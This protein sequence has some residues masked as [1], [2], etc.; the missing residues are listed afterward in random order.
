MAPDTRLALCPGTFDPVTYGHLDVISRASLRPS[1]TNN[2]ATKSS[3]ARLVSA[4]IR[5]TEGASG[6]VATPPLL[7]STAVAVAGCNV[8]ED[9]DPGSVSILL[10]NGDGT[11]Q[12]HVDFTV[13]L[14]PLAPAIGD[15]NG[16]GGVDLVVSNSFSNTVSVMLNL[17]VMAAF[18]SSINFGN[19]IV[20]K[21]SEPE[22]VALSNPSGTP[23]NLHSIAITGVNAADFAQNNNCPAELS[24][25][26]Q[27]TINVTFKPR[28]KG[29]RRADI[30]L[31]DSVPGSPQSIS[32]RGT[33]Q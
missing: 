13:G 4:T 5:L 6:R 33:G 23:F 2:G 31:S 20:G 19:E 3:G 18:P 7:D 10:G 8:G 24:P 22:S 32:L 11:F 16:D 30:K 17:P 29:K 1:A 12:P 25:G 26:A 15:L 14:V 27:C 21:K 9:C 28:A